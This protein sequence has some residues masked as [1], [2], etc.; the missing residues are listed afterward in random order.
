M[1]ENLPAIESMIPLVEAFF[2]QP[3]VL[4][5]LEALMRRLSAKAS[6]WAIGGALRNLFIQDMHGSSPPTRD[7]DLVI[8]GQAAGCDLAC[9][10]PDEKIRPIE[11][12]GVRWYPAA[13]RF[14]FDLCRIEDFIVI[15]KFKLDPTPE[16]LLGA[17][18]LD[19][20]A[21]IYGLDRRELR[22]KNCLGAIAART[23]GRNSPLVLDKALL[24]YRCLLIRYKT[25]FLLSEE[26]FCFLKW[27]L[28]LD[29]LVKLRAIIASKQDKA[30]AKALLTDYRKLCREKNYA[31]Y[32][33]GC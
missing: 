22:E 17:L 30:M 1:L 5:P 23:I 33:T 12:G 27:N 19:V 25:G 21:V 29:D 16:S 8:E 13:S 3:D 2:S 24:A 9:L 18:D 31:S 15:D 26:L 14:A 28:A 32:R 10:L 4:R 11:L 7:I 20:N 6:L